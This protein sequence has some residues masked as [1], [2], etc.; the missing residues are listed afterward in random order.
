MGQRMAAG[1]G[2]HGN[3]VGGDRQE[4]HH[5]IGRALTDR[6]APHLLLQPA[7]P[8]AKPGHGMPGIRR[9]GDEPIRRHST[10]QADGTAAPAVVVRG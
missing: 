3:A 8:C 9:I 2:L 5:E 6:V 1:R 4:G 10:D 7:R